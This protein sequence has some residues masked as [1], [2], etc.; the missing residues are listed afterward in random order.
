MNFLYYKN[1][2]DE[3]KSSSVSSHTSYK[4]KIKDPRKSKG[5]QHGYEGKETKKLCMFPRCLTVGTHPNLALI[6]LF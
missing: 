1:F 3:N 6:S 4:K 2:G 5:L